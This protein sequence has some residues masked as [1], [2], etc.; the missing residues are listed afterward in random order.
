MKSL[1]FKI[2]FITFLPFLTQAQTVRWASEVVNY[3]SQ[4][5]PQEYSA[6]Q[7]LGNPDVLPQG[8]DSPNI[9]L[10]KSE[11][12]VEFVTV[13]FD[14]LMQISQVAIAE[15]Y[16]PSA[17]YQ[18]YLI[19]ETN[20][21]YLLNTFRPTNIPLPGRIKNIFF[22][23]TPYRVKAVK[24]VINGALVPGYSGIDAIAISTTWDP[25]ETQ[26][27][28]APT[29][30]TDV[31][32]ERL[33]DNVNS[34]Y[35]EYR[36]LIAPDGKT[37]YFSRSFHPENIGGEDDPEDIWVSNFNKET[38]KW[39][40]AV[41]AG[42][43][44][45][46]KGANYISSITPD[47]NSMVVILG[48]EYKNNKMKPGL[49]IASK[50]SEG[51]SEIENLN[52]KGDYIYTDNG[53]YFLANNRQV[54]LLAIDRYDAF[55]MKDLYV[56][57]KQEDGSW[58]EPMNLGNDI[59][60]AD[61]DLSPFLAADNETLY[62][63]SRGYSGFGESDIYISRRLDDTWQNWTEPENLGLGINSSGDDIFFN[64]P[65]SGEFAYFTKDFDETQNTDIHRIE[66]PIFFRPAPVITLSG[67]VKDADNNPVKAEISYTLLPEETEVGTTLSDQKTGEYEISLPTGSAYIILAEAP[68]FI[69]KKKNV[70]Y[71]TMD[72]F[73]NIKLD[74]VLEP[75]IVAKEPADKPD[76]EPKENKPEENISALDELKAL[77][78]EID[79]KFGFNRDVLP[80]NYKPELDRLANLVKE[81][82]VKLKINGHTD[83][84]GD[85]DY[86]LR[87]S[88]RRADAVE[89]YL[90]TKGVAARKIST[91]GYGETKPVTSNDTAEG[92]A[93]NRRVELIIQD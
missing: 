27:N 75:A 85:A 56:S 38:G 28:V 51:W 79:I 15:S 61:E 69:P 81:T 52:V 46:N 30:K 34:E 67:I 65:P 57:F 2:I 25:V 89:S 26:K 42:A 59:N 80:S 32:I 73:Q 17:L 10:P 63:S 19:D 22:Q 68:G 45:N 60:T 11:S 44:L 64:I 35:N 77:I 78:S 20:K 29:A 1:W 43:P 55:G 13:S 6:E 66:L 41:N 83:S 4:L 72:E 21:Q 18:V 50:T 87:L 71:S 93:E 23:E 31:V 54:L 5:S 86:N 82:D 48:N 14:T 84:V 9:W 37:L 36:P 90:K 24:V 33:S 62:F 58:T 7:V 47:G 12:D 92:R 88:K 3:S 70:D 91:E 8:G 76:D 74:I 39:E 40:P 53:D 49:S 16:N